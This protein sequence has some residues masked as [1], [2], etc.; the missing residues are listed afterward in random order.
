MSGLRLVSGLTKRQ[1]VEASQAS[2]LVQ[3]T[4]VFC[5]VFFLPALVLA[6]S[7]SAETV[8]FFSLQNKSSCL[9]MS[10]AFQF[11]MSTTVSVKFTFHRHCNTKYECWKPPT[12]L[13]LSARSRGKIQDFLRNYF[14]VSLFTGKNIDCQG[15]RFLLLFP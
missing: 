4:A 5:A 14:Y 1:K 8:I 3:D 11:Q 6:I 15:T 10:H 13:I 9:S 2:V 7:T 12:L